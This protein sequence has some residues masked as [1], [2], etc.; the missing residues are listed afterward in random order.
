MIQSSPKSER[1]LLSLENGPSWA[2]LTIEA[3]TCTRPAATEGRVK[4]GA[5]ERKR[6][7]EA[8]RAAGTAP[9]VDSGGGSITLPPNTTPP[10]IVEEIEGE[11]RAVSPVMVDG[12]LT[13]W[14]SSLPEPPPSCGPH[15]GRYSG[16][17]GRDAAGAPVRGGRAR[18]R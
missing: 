1:D 2:G 5:D 7:L 8:T 4:G 13:V 12:G 14:N 18:W 9:S 11:I 16:A 10:G 15:V 3:H 6:S 17:P